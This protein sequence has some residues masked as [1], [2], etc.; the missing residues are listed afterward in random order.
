MAA[1]FAHGRNLCSQ[2]VLNHGVPLPLSK[3]AFG[4]VVFLDGDVGLG[5]LHRVY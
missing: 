1:V 3:S 2:R 4:V 5:T